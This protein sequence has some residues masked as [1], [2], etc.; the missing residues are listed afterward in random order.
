MRLQT[1]SE[2]VKAILDDGTVIRHGKAYSWCSKLLQKLHSQCI[3]RVVFDTRTVAHGHR[4]PMGSSAALSG[5]MHTLRAS[6]RTRARIFRAKYTA[7]ADRGLWTTLTECCV[8]SAG[9]GE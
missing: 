2:E 4:L 6:F 7:S 1:C 5:A 3:E 9:R 8:I